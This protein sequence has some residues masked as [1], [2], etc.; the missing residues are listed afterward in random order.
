MDGVHNVSWIGKVVVGG[1]RRWHI[2][3]MNSSKKEL[4]EDAA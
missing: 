1:H 4:S 2:I 3:W